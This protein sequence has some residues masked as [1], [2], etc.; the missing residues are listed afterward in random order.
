MAGRSTS[1]LVGAGRRGVARKGG[2]A[3]AAVA[4]A[5]V[6]VG[7]GS[8]DDEPA[9]AA[10]S[11]TTAPAA[12]ATSGGSV[13]PYGGD[14]AATTAPAGTAPA[15]GAATV[16]IDNFAFDPQSSTF[17]V[18]QTVT[19]VNKDSAPHTWTSSDGGFD[20]GTIQPGKSGTVTLSKAGTFGVVC[21]IHPN[22]TGTVTVQG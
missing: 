15:A 22:M 13:N 21:T 16:T 3:V 18:G 4:L 6:L 9:S 12:A 10:A 8:D 7:C 5:V 14:S 17:K 2:A 19:V 1:A 11:A 20:T